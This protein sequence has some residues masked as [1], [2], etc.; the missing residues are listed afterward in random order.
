LRSSQNTRKNFL[1]QINGARGKKQLLDNDQFGFRPNRSCEMQMLLYTKYLAESYDRN[2]QVHA[3]Y[4]DLQKAFD[5]VPHIE[6]LY[7]LRSQFGITGKVLHWINAFLSGRRQRVNV[8]QAYSS[9]VNVTSGVPQGTILAPILFIMYVQ[10]MQNGLAETEI[11]FLKFADDTK[12]FTEIRSKSDE[13]N[14]QK[15]LSIL[16]DWFEKWK[17]P[18]NIKSGVI[19]FGRTGKSDLSYIL[20]SEEMK[21]LHR[22]RDLGIIMDETLSYK[23]HIETVVNKAMRTYGW[24][25]RN[26]TTRDRQVVV[27][28]YKT[29]IRPTLEYASSVWSPS[30][31]GMNDRLEKVQKKITKLV[32]RNA[33]SYSDRLRTLKLPSLR[34]RR[35]Y[36]DLLKVF[37]VVHGD[38]KF[39]K[40][41]FTLSAEIT[42]SNLRR[43]RLAIYKNK[44]HT[45][46]LKHHFTNRMVDQWNALPEE[47]L[48]IPGVKFKLFKTKLK[49][50]L[51]SHD[52]PYD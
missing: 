34:W 12:L 18:A 1:V 10:D 40:Q 21:I 45:D 23:A 43:H 3:I 30:R 46:L 16:G 38:Q 22:E 4:L 26:L 44:V 48:D 20:H 33:G 28:V 13:E 47:L 24:L 17:M 11:K 49:V 39:R 8:G 41:L 5:K 19:K 50:H 6:L 15:N 36:L 27:K 25:S 7:K 37:Q 29:L 35:N 9:W 32:A 31:V 52:S 2:H 42:D 14:L 51:L